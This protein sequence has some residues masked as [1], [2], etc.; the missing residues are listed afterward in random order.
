M[1]ALLAAPACGK[2]EGAA[3]SAPK[4]DGKAPPAQ[5]APK[6]SDEKKGGDHGAEAALGTVPL[7]GYS[8]EVARLGAIAPGAASD[9]GAASEPPPVPAAKPTA[10]AV[11]AAGVV[12]AVALFACLALPAWVFVAEAGAA[13]E[14]IDVFHAALLGASLVYFVSGSIWVYCRTRAS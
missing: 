2:D 9:P 12:A 8:L 11:R 10:P 1:S 5:A 14:R 4:G 6:A 7:G 3:P 13:A